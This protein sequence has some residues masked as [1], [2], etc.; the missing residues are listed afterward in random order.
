MTLIES[1][2]FT[3]DQYRDFLTLAKRKYSFIKY[4]EID[5]SRKFILWRHDV[6]F[7]LNRA[8]RL[9]QIEA[10]EGVRS[11]FFINPHCEFY[12]VLEKSQTEIIRRIISMGHAIGLHFDSEYYATESE[13]QLNDAVAFEAD[14]LSR[15]FGC[16]IVAFSFHNPTPLLL[17]FENTTYGGLINCYSKDFKTRIGYC[18]DSNGRWQHRHLFDVINRAEEEY[19]QILT[20]PAWWQKRESTPKRKIQRCAMGRANATL[21]LHDYMLMAADRFEEG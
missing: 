11:T 8:E 3:E 10:E 1:N 18:S 9:A 2:A 15:M 16:K 7:S 5:F 21:D 12:S 14:W 4:D 19:L 20:H 17:S 13:E 6:D